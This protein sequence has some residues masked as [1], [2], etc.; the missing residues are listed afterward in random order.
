MLRSSILRVSYKTVHYT[1][2]GIAS[3]RKLPHLEPHLHV[4][5]VAGGIGYLLKTPNTGRKPGLRL[6]V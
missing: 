3:T 1:D 4:N 2:N 5:G 6:M